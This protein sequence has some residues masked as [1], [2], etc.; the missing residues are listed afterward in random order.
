[1]IDDLYKQKK[2]LEKNQ[3]YFKVFLKIYKKKTIEIIKEEEQRAGL[4]D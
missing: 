2:E 1:M 3:D 4:G